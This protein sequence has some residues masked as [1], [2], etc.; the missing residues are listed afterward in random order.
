MKKNWFPGLMAREEKRLK[1][2]LKLVDLAVEV[3]DARIP[4]TSR[5]K[6][7]QTLL[8][9]KKRILVLNKSDL[10][11]ENITRQWAQF[12]SGEEM[13]VLIFSS[14]TGHQVKRLEKILKGYTPKKTRFKK[15]FRLMV[16]GIPNVG[17]SSV[18]NRLIGKPSA[19]T[20]GEPGITRGPQWIKMRSGWEMLDTPGLLAPSVDSEENALALA[21]TGN[22]SSRVSDEE[23]VAW[24]LLNKL[25]ALQKVPSFMEYYSLN[26]S[27]NITPESLFFQVGENR[28]CFAA[29]GK[30]DPE[31]TAQVILRDFKKGYWGRITLERPE[32]Y[33]ETS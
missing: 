28:G 27:G 26:F 5:N 10:A 31:K 3:L 14:Y 19:R 20:G 9:D 11:E 7:L 22:L 17:K 23:S 18:I 15:P 2:N 33:D 32:D 1:E 16:V 25:I 29:G 30:V 6:K 24:W 4:L 21:A 8:G 12:F 13:P